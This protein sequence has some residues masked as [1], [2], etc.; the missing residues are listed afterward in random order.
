MFFPIMRERAKE[1]EMNEC[2]DECV[3]QHDDTH[4]VVSKQ[5]KQ[6]QSK[7]SKQCFLSHS[8]S[9]SKLKRKIESDVKQHTQ[10]KQTTSAGC[11]TVLPL[12]ETSR[13]LRSSPDHRLKAKS[14]E[15]TSQI[16]D[17]EIMGFREIS[18]NSIGTS[19]FSLANTFEKSRVSKLKICTPN[20]HCLLYTSPSPRD[21]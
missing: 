14:R 2:V 17:G 13:C 16:L 21:A 9:H 18:E 5:S 3:M 12:P 8:S 20:R 15:P 11:A 6:K 19:K 10:H 4:F 1:I 7:Q